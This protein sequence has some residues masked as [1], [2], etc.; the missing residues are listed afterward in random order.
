MTPEEREEAEII[1]GLSLQP[2]APKAFKM[3]SPP[4][5]MSRMMVR[6]PECNIRIREVGYAAHWSKAHRQKHQID[7]FKRWRKGN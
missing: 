3:E 2:P 7:F 4:Y 5:G 6:C 1:Y